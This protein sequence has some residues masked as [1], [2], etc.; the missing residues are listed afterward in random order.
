MTALF[1]LNLIDFMVLQA[2]ALR[3]RIG[4]VRRIDRHEL[5]DQRAEM[6]FLEGL[7]DDSLLERR[8]K[9]HIQKRIDAIDILLELSPAFQG[10]L[11]TDRTMRIVRNEAGANAPVFEGPNITT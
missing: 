5:L 7:L 8:V 11:I 6:I 1:E 9:A 4:K 2:A 10:V 3:R